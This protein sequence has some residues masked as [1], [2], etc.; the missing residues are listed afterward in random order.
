MFASL[1][2]FSAAAI[3]GVLG[4]LHLLYT[5]HGVKLHPRDPRVQRRMQQTAMVI[6]PDTSMWRAWI[7]FNTSHSLCALLF[8]LVYGYLALAQPTLLFDAPFLLAVALG[9]LATLLWVAWRYW[10]R[11]P[12]YGIALA[13]VC[14]AAATLA[15]TMGV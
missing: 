14:C 10:F 3:I 4:A 8:A 11:I 1:A 12:F 6:T 7:G 13:L 15:A 2:M 9:L 5:F